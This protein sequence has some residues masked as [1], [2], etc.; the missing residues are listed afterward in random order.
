MGGDHLGDLLVGV[1]ERVAE[2]LG[3]GEVARLAFPLRDHL[4]GDR[5][6]HP[7]GEPVLAPLG[8]ERVG[9]D[10]EYVLSD[11]RGEHVVD[12]ALGDVRERD[13]AGAREAGS[14]HRHR[15]DQLPLLGREGVEASGEQ[16]VEARGH[17]ELADLAGEPEPASVLGEH[18]AVGER[19][20]RFDRVEGDSL[21]L[22]DDLPQRRRREIRDQPPQ[23]LADG[24][25]GERLERE[26]GP[27]RNADRPVRAALAELRPREGTDEDRMIGRPVEQLLDEVEQ[28]VVGPLH[29]LEEEDDRVVLGEPFEEQAPAREQV[30][31]LEP[32]LGGP[33]QRPEGRRD[34]P[35][36]LGIGD[37]LVEPR[38]ELRRRLPA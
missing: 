11:Q 19:A 34:A 8:R 33:D 10:R 36:L 12:A 14:E 30:L 29:V 27:A 32:R 37:P 21:S 22:R 9:A 31:A 35:S 3:G 26:S 23:Q 2:V 6:E 20:H 17:V 16:R 38:R 25:P 4:V 5:A 1:G 13:D 18:A 24:I 7:L 28:S 15:L